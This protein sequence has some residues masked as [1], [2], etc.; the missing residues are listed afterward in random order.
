VKGSSW[1]LALGIQ[2]MPTADGEAFIVKKKGRHFWRPSFV[3][4]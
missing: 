1:Q 3:G 2:L 4:G